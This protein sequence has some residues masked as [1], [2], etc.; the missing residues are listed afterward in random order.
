MT[1]SLFCC[2]RVGY[3]I[4]LDAIFFTQCLHLLSTAEHNLKKHTTTTV[5][6]WKRVNSNSASF[7]LMTDAH[8]SVTHSV[9]H[10]KKII[11]LLFPAIWCFV[12]VFIMLICVIVPWNIRHK[13]LTGFLTGFYG[14]SHR[15]DRVRVGRS[16]LDN[17]CSD[18]RHWQYKSPFVCC[19]VTFFTGC[20]SCW[21]AARGEQSMSIY[22]LYD[23]YIIHVRR[24]LWQTS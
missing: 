18:D 14:Q 2:L 8:C 9:T 13:F 19:S 15:C 16:G 4:H 20:L 23:K 10:H 1:F 6:Q 7:C 17:H 11:K 12:N 3:C 22:S 5:S 21:L 24:L